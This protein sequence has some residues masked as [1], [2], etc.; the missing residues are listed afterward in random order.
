MKRRSFF[1]LTATTLAAPFVHAQQAGRTYRV[2]LGFQVTST[3]AKPLEQAFLDGLREHG[4]VIGRNLVVDVR[5][6]D[7]DAERLPAIVDQL[8]ALKPEVLAGFE[9]MARAMKARTSTIPIVLTNSSDP[10][11]LGLIQSF[12]RPGGNVTGV[13]LQLE[14]LPPKHV[15]IMREILP[16]LSRIGLLLDT[17]FAGS[18]ATEEN[19]RTA[20]QAL[21]AN[22]ILY[23]FGNREELES[24]FARMV[25]D[26]PDALISSGGGVFVQFRK[27]IGENS[28]R[29]RIPYGGMG[30]ASGGE[31]DPALF[32]YGPGLLQAYRD[33]AR[34]VDRILKGAKPAD[35]PV[36]M[37]AKFN[38]MVN[39]QSARVLG[40]K[41]PQSVLAR[42]TRIIE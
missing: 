39:L 32:A 18:K 31:T 16:Q 19:T 15:E 8:I 23:R 1:V 7:G 22:V 26:R 36:E 40:I 27:L 28:Q 17:S 3:V 13:S 12:R 10:V 38:L 37:P 11:G 20:A 14:E 9:T 30:L 41:V 6:A 24:A 25:N 34:Y 4:L 33:A 2:G 21:G 29:L 35:L 5:Y 42:A